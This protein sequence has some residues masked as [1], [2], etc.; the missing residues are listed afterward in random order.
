M[1]AVVSTPTLAWVAAI[2]GSLTGVNQSSSLYVTVNI[3]GAWEIQIPIQ[4]RYS[5]ISADPTVAV[6]A[7]SDG[8]ANYDTT[9]MTGMSIVRVAVATANLRTASLRL[10]TGQY[11][12]QLIASGPN[13]QSFAVLTGMVVTAINNL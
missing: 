6:Y 4:A 12:I 2:L 10:P 3:T 9:P 8:G 13:S 1:A 5:A 7:S 11:L